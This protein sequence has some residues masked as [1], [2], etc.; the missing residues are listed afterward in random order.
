[1]AEVAEMCVFLEYV[2]VYCNGSVHIH[3]YTYFCSGPP[4]KAAAQYYNHCHRN[5][6]Q[7]RNIKLSVSL[8]T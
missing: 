2:C 6:R 4:R 7:Q 8:M 5:G 1:M 3:I